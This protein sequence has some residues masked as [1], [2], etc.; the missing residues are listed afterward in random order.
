[1]NADQSASLSL[2]PLWDVLT[3]RRFHTVVFP[4]IEGAAG[5]L[6]AATLNLIQNQG[7]SAFIRASLNF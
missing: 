1:M 7:N 5:T 4:G 2:M 3:L 6:H